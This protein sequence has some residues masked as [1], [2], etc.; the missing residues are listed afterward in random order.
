MNSGVYKLCWADCEVYY[1]GASTDLSG[2]KSQHYYDLRVCRH[3]NHTVQTTYQEYGYPEFEILTLCE[4]KEDLY[5][6]EKFHLEQ[7]IGD[8]FCANVYFDPK[9]KGKIMPEEHKRMLMEINKGRV[10]SEETRRKI[11]EAHKGRTVSEETRGKISESAKAKVFSQTHKDNIS[12]AIS[13]RKHYKAKKVI[14]TETGEVYG[15]L[16]EIV[17]SGLVPYAQSSFRCILN[18]TIKTNPTPYEYLD[19][20]EANG[21]KKR[22]DRVRVRPNAKKVIN[23]ET[24][25]IYEC[26]KDIVALGLS[27]K[28]YSN[29][30]SIL[31]GH[32]KSNPT[33]YM[34]LD[35]YEK[36]IACTKI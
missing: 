8:P 34:Y 4:T 22:E 20:Y 17:L 24:G 11:S 28:A 1:I 32:I 30:R 27:D 5:E 25:E 35:N 9:G 29:L 2:R 18:G 19:V 15:C 6:N 16:E 23:T 21:N 33:P 10:A 26:S 7:A 31:S 36:G 14:N 12:K 3:H 13:G